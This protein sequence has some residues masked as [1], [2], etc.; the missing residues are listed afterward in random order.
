M[1]WL[2]RGSVLLYTLSHPEHSQTLEGRA[3]YHFA[4]CHLQI[5]R[6]GQIRSIYIHN[7]RVTFV[8]GRQTGVGMDLINA[9]IFHV[10][11]VRMC[12]VLP[13]RTRKPLALDNLSGRAFMSLCFMFVA[14]VHL[15][16]S[17][18][19]NLVL[20]TLAPKRD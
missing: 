19:S 20:N 7:F 8:H 3:L 17:Y 6:I 18:N 11:T 9:C 10:M 13:Y 5:Y 14:S 15:W 16:I 4:E 2:R 12:G 1:L